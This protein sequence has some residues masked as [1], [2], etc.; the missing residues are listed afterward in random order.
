MPVLELERTVPAPRERVYAVAKDIER[1]PEFMPSVSSVRIVEHGE[2]Q[3]SEW[4]GYIEEFKRQ[5]KW[6]EEDYWDDT[7][8]RCRFRA[9]AGDWDRYE[10]TWEFLPAGEGTLMRLR[11]DYDF[12][13]PLIGALIKGLLAKLVRKNSEEMMEGIARQAAAASS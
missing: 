5:L 11:V 12:N 13:V 3:V 8:Q 7:A 4:V 9:I 10:G 6:T 2:R 1:F